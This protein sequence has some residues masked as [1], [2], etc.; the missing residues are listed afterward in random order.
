MPIDFDFDSS[1]SS[2][3]FGKS[4]LSDAEK[5]RKKA[6]KRQKKIRNVG[7]L[8]S[9]L[10][11]GDMFLVNNAKKKVKLFESNLLDQKALALNRINNATQFKTGELD[12]LQSWGSWSLD[13]NDPRQWEDGGLIYNAIKANQGAKLRSVW[14]LGQ[15]QP[16]PETD[17]TKF[18]TEL[19]LATSN[20][21]NSLQA[22]Y[23]KFKPSIGKDVKLVERQYGRLLEEGTK[24]ILSPR[25][26]SSIRK[27]LGKF[28]ILNK[29][30]PHLKKQETSLFG[31]DIYFD[32]N[33]AEAHKQ[34]LAELDQADIAYKEKLADP[35]GQIKQ[36]PK[37]VN[38]GANE[39]IKKQK[40]KHNLAFNELARYSYQVDSTTGTA[41]TSL[42]FAD[43]SQNPNIENL[44]AIEIETI[45]GKTAQGL[46]SLTD[47]TTSYRFSEL[48][49]D[50]DNE[51]RKLFYHGVE[52]QYA[53]ILEKKKITDNKGEKAD[54]A[55]AYYNAW[56]SQITTNIER[57]KFRRGKEFN[58]TV[59]P[60][61]EAILDDLKVAKGLVQEAD[62]AEF[63]ENNPVT[64]T[65][66]EGGDLEI[67]WA[68][69]NPKTNEGV[70]DIRPVDEVLDKFEQQIQS[71]E[72][73]ED[74]ENIFEEANNQYQEVLV[75][76]FIKIKNEYL[77]DDE[78]I[79]RNPFTDKVIEEKTIIVPKGNLKIKLSMDEEGNIEQLR[80]SMSV[81]KQQISF[82]DIPEGS[83]KQQIRNLSVQYYVAESLGGRREPV[84]VGR[85]EGLASDIDVKGDI[86]I[87][88]I[89]A[90]TYDPQKIGGY[91]P[92][93]TPEKIF[94]ASKAE[95]LATTKAWDFTA[96]GEGSFGI[97]LFG[98]V[99]KGAK[100]LTGKGIITYTNEGQ[101]IIN[102]IDLAGLGD[103]D[104]IRQ[105][106]KDAFNDQRT[107]DYIASLPYNILSSPS[108]TK[109]LSGTRATSILEQQE[110][111]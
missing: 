27:I 61:E 24:Q 11:V 9:G 51:E 40:T 87:E 99:I 7:Y 108:T 43:S 58:V 23:T 21:K 3:E 68:V 6:K 75:S 66:N 98:P 111:G 86:S 19:E 64:V 70:I 63:I 77:D 1:Q 8:L 82:D 71:A 79:F 26:T 57:E 2:F 103:L 28:D 22:K 88:S 18:N 12:D 46:G 93:M 33:L 65:E 5:R 25:N 35:G 10:R 20:A 14:G 52:Y 81:K 92:E 110:G 76:Q 15:N 39:V 97:N 78:E 100:L 41:K 31:V 69:I 89:V 37:R 50:M 13:Y 17:L 107:Q 74:K 30:E 47:G 83:I 102:K 94:D 42:D 29:V 72:T 101:E 84:T 4:L 104:E 85:V 67:S 80:K 62:N 106:F 91:N 59:R 48:W 38:A 45:I 95:I 105:L 54:I 16:L 90:G 73:N 32:E 60:L 44:D 34:R 36:D 53:L 49:N 56:N 96:R 109:F 55:Q